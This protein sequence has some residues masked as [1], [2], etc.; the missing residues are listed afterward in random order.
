MQTAGE[1]SYQRGGTTAEEIKTHNR[2]LRQQ[3]REAEATGTHTN[4]DNEGR[5]LLG[6]KLE[7]TKGILYCLPQAPW[8]T[9]PGSLREFTETQADLHPFILLALRCIMHNPVQQLLDR[10]NSAPCNENSKVC[11]SAI[12]HRLK[13]QCV[14][15]LEGRTLLE[16]MMLEKLSNANQSTMQYLNN[17]YIEGG[18]TYNIYRHLEYSENAIIRKAGNLINTNIDKLACTELLRKYLAKDNADSRNSLYV[19]Y[20]EW[21]I[22]QTIVSTNIEKFACTEF[23]K[24]Y[25]V[26]AA[27]DGRDKLYESFSDC[28]SAIT[29]NKYKTLISTNIK[30]TLISTNVEK[31][32][33][34]ELLN[35]YL[36]GG[37]L[38]I[39]S[40]LYEI[41]L[42]HFFPYLNIQV[43]P[44]HNLWN[45]F[46]SGVIRS[47]NFNK[48]LQPLYSFQNCIWNR[49][50]SSS[51]VAATTRKLFEQNIETVDTLA[52]GQKRQVTAMVVSSQKK[53]KGKGIASQRP[54]FW[55]G[56]TH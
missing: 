3:K 21:I 44:Q 52:N 41:Y 51:N 43:G 33:Y 12:S 28:D 4:A 13:Q 54:P 30:K 35:D 37:C 26:Q 29:L 9:H 53:A 2:K 34:I 25:T 20:L 14:Y 1:G 5:E 49:M 22:A 55:L 17:E 18:G 47:N 7:E 46:E 56:T 27:L 6:E 10:N 40:R 36:V 31:H 50:T 19:R 16:C 15:G 45:G 38:A 48:S 23:T 42:H 24:K 39:R 11:L 32:S 8:P